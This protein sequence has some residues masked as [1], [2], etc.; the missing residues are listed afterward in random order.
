MAL[1]KRPYKGT[2]DFF[3]PQMR[4][5]EY[6]LSHMKETAEI[7]GYAPYDGPLLEEEGLYRAKSG[8]ELIDEQIYSFID[9]GGRSV[10]IRPE[11]TPTLARMVAQVQREWPKPIR[12]YSI[13]NLFRYERPQRGRFREHWQFNCDIFGSPG[14][15]GELEILQL[16]VVLMERLGADSSHFEILINDRRSLD[17]VFQKKMNLD[18]SQALVLMKLVDKS[19]KLEKVAFEIMVKELVPDKKQQTIFFSYMESDRDFISSS[20]VDLMKEG[21]DEFGLKDYLKYD[22]T[23]VRGLDYYTGIVFEIYDKHQENRRAIAGGGA[24]DGLMQLFDEP[25]LPGVGFGLGDVTLQN[26]VRTHGLISD[27]SRPTNDLFLSF[28][29]EE[30]RKVAL[31]LALALRRRGLKVVTELEPMKMKKVFTTGEKKGA[32]FVAIMGG[33]ELKEHTV[34]IKELATKRQVPFNVNEVEKIVEYLKKEK[35]KESYGTP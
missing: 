7:F 35:E 15:Q 1:S 19:K 12:L 4:E 32:R 3:P 17:D 24:Y 9:R 26:F 33:E 34:Q 6:L 29:Q 21:E 28:Q 18:K 2:R 16:A 30:C 10:S 11:M 31:Q 14:I 13:P 23:I 20:L 22:P 8:Q 25:D 27:F 5:R